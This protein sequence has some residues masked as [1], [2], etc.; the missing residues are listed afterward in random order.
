[1]QVSLSGSCT[2]CLLFSHSH[3]HRTHMHSSLYTF[4]LPNLLFDRVIY[5]RLAASCD[6]CTPR[7]DTHTHTTCGP[8]SLCSHGLPLCHLLP[9]LSV[10]AC[11]C[12]R[13][14][15]ADKHVRSCLDVCVP[16]CECTH[17]SPLPP[18]IWPCLPA[19]YILTPRSGRKTLGATD[20]GSAG[21]NSPE[22]RRS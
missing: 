4:T 16:E 8:T 9:P 11:A 14:F 7:H 22:A 21:T 12:A 20:G 6:T 15:C 17:V 10:R 2:S 1:M 3:A 19:P 18:E 5:G 13:V